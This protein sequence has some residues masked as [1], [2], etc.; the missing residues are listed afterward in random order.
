MQIGRTQK[1]NVQHN[2]T[3]NQKRKNKYYHH[4]NKHTRKRLIETTKI[5]LGKDIID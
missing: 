5:S 4:T 1:Q 2:S 3:Q